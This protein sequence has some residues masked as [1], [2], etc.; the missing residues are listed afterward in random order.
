MN[1]Y[2]GLKE[3][4]VSAS[5]A[6][7]GNN[8]ITPPS[9]QSAWRLFF[10]KFDDPIIRILLIA[11]AI[12]I[13]V[14]VLEGHYAEG[15]GIIIAVFLATFL[16]FFNEYKAGKEFSLLNK[17]SDEVEVK[18]FRS[19][20][21]STVYR[22][23]IVV[24]DI[25]ILDLGDEVPADGELL[26]SVNL[27][28]NESAL[29]GEPVCAKAANRALSDANATYPSY[30]VLRGTTVVD[31]N[32]IFKVT[33]VGDHTEVGKTAQEAMVETNSVTPL[34]RQ[35]NRLSK[36]IGVVGFGC[37]TLLFA[38]LCIRDVYRGELVFSELQWINAL[39]LLVFASFALS[40]IWTPIF[41][42]GL[43]LFHLNSRK[44]QWMKV[45]NP[46]SWAI[47]IAVGASLYLIFSVVVWLRGDSLFSADA[48][49]S[50]QV[51]ERILL[52]FMVAITLIVVAVPEGLA[53]SVTLS[54]AYSMRKMLASH[55]L[56]RKMHATETMGATTVI[57]TDK[58]GTLTENQMK[59]QQL[60]LESS[61]G[62]VKR[63]VNESFS[64]NT[65][66][67]V[68]SSQS[69]NDKIVGNPTEG[70]LL[71]WL[72]GEGVDYLDVR[73]QGVIVEQLAFTT[74]NKFMATLAV[75]NNEHVLFVKGAPE[76]VLNRCTLVIGEA[77]EPL[78]V[79]SRLQNIQQ[80]LAEQQ[81]LA[82]RTLG[83]AY[84]SF[85]SSPNLSAGL[86]ELCNDLTFIGFVS[87]SD[88]VR[89]DVPQA[90][91]ECL[92]AGID[93][94]VVTGDTALTAGE[95]GRQIGLFPDEAALRLGLITGGEFSALSEEEALR[96]APGIRV[97]ARAKPS[98]K[99][100]LV[101]ILQQ[102]GNVVAVT[103]DGTNDAPAMNHA[104]V[105]LA[106]G[107]GTSVAREA[108]EI[109][110]LDDSFISIVSAVRWGRSLYLNIQRFILF[111]LTINVLAMVLVL[112]GPFLGVALPLTVTQ[113]LWVN[114][115]M[116]TFAA[117][118]LATEPSDPKVMSQ[119]PRR[120]DAF[121]VTKA[122]AIQIFITA[123]V[124]LI[125]CIIFLVFLKQ[126]GTVTNK[127]LSLFFTSFVML[128]F[129]NLFNVRSYGTNKS[130]FSGL[131]GNKNF[132]LIAAVIFIGQVV[133]VS[134]GGQFFRTVA[135]SFQ[136]WLVVVGATSLVLW[137]GEVMRYF[138]RTRN[139][140]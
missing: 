139:L 29:T 42:D 34:T 24:D 35:L 101:K 58:T 9:K 57:C 84:R 68:D 116:D 112:I 105:G 50:L 60:F 71:L 67:H 138:Y 129:W 88:P 7:F 40:G 134:F 113:M 26:E 14:G 123:F 126:D 52:Y 44:I 108:S 18:V 93:V 20:T 38:S 124:F 47:S 102:L 82:M 95:I 76:I 120:H 49:F 12:A 59:V 109:I 115:I 90:I 53:M 41:F 11:A 3:S 127:E 78:P 86:K 2:V 64:I 62:W 17:A 117:L 107:S 114:L 51:A 96:R 36:V 56:V 46:T 106:M 110:L 27:Q 55:N 1:K 125:S 132:L 135:L 73:Q 140:T 70:A 48:W 5:R 122:M 4:E 19:G 119:K 94:K 80:H 89:G 39:G 137:I 92:Q 33:A 31:G 25:V 85:P 87:I 23:D 63:L 98:D 21:V 83:F 121:I 104:D 131:R 133:I 99:L 66:A 15:V 103:G 81:T 45:S 6:R 79:N 28:L 61:A 10:E 43:E 111:Q 136:E 74:E 97:M 54:L 100:R 30:V 118:A 69:G 75:I 8:I 16:S 22:K 77:N 65:T 91:S 128:Q 13:V 130:A 72:K 32:G 37:A